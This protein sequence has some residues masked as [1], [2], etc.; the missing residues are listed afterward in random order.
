MLVGT[1]LKAKIELLLKILGAH[2]QVKFFAI[3]LIGL[4]INIA[5]F[6]IDVKRGSPPSKKRKNTAAIMAREDQAPAEVQ[7]VQELP[8]EMEMESE[9]ESEQVAAPATPLGTLTLPSNATSIRAD[10]TDNFS[11]ANK[12]YGYYA[13]VEND[14]Q[15]F[16]VCLPVTY[17][18][19]RENTFRWSFICPEETIFSQESFTCMRRED[20]T[21]ECEDSARYYE[22]NGNFGGAPV[23][24]EEKQQEQAAEPEEQQ[25]SEKD[26]QPVEAAP[27]P[28]PAPVAQP[29]KPVKVQSKPK[30][31]P[32]RRK[33]QPQ[34]K[35][36]VTEAAPVAAETEAVA[37]PVAES[38][39]GSSP[40]RFT[41]RPHKHQAVVA[42]PAPA[43]VR[44]EL[45]AGIRKRP[46]IFNK[47]TTTPK[48]VEEPA[49]TE[50]AVVELSEPAPT[51]QLQTMFED[52]APVQ[53]VEE[54][55]EPEVQAS[56]PA[57]AIAQPEEATPEGAAP[58]KIETET[59]LEEVKPIEAIEEIPAVIFESLEATKPQDTEVEKQK[60]TEEE[61]TQ[62]T[63]EKK[64]KDTEEKK[65]KD[66]E[67]EQPKE[68]EEVKPVEEQ[69]KEVPAV[70]EEKETP[71][72]EEEKEVPAKVEEI[73][74][75]N[76]NEPAIME[77]DEEIL[78]NIEALEAAKPS[79]APESIPATPEMQEHSPLVEQ[80]LLDNKETQE[81]LGGFKP[82]DPVMAAEAEQLITDFLNTLKKNEEKPETELATAAMDMAEILNEKL[83]EPQ[84]TDIKQSPDVSIEE[85][86]LP[87]PE[88]VDKNA[89]IEE[90][91]LEESELQKSPEKIMTDSPIINIMQY[92]HL[93]MDY[94]I[95]VQVIPLEQQMQ[96]QIETNAQPEASQEVK[97]TAAVPEEV[98]EAVP[99]AQ[100]VEET[101]QI[102]LE[103][104]PEIKPDESPIHNDDVDAPQESIA[105][106][107]YM[108]SI[109]IDDIVELVKERLDQTP[110][111]EQMAP[112]ELVITPGA[113]AP[114]TLIQNP[115]PEAQSESETK[116]ESEQ[117]SQPEQELILPIYK[118]IS[119]AEP[120]MSKVQTLPVTVSKV[121]TETETEKE[122]QPEVREPKS[123][124]RD[125]MDARKRRFLFRAD[126]S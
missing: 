103:T 23:Q 81:S 3:A 116:S 78:S 61:E 1:F 11:C 25:Q 91:L 92:N 60:E 28:A 2:L 119:M 50:A 99:E 52:A 35:A 105:T 54:V 121:E 47:P 18:D 17:A 101:S 57:V 80:L 93:P 83:E 125:K 117:E 67:E 87:E 73:Q 126:A 21:I 22:L 45:F 123:Q 14:C 124:S 41:M 96:P 71:A 4:L 66:T 106:A 34:R 97:E 76:R 120:S 85:A 115:K 75:G 63:E 53:T 58:T 113:A 111:N 15:I 49:V 122:S 109:S 110:K 27:E 104:E 9:S 20:M 42:A 74:E 118:R 5:R 70:E 24:E 94:Q 84:E 44:N 86:K 31:K 102:Q 88:I 59:R 6:W 39:P 12:T 82:V 65:P 69:T 95:P 26:K 7:E 16:H 33:P 98:K 62:Y 46:A 19:G 108:P 30:P 29:S 112:M 56:E 32:N 90:Q 13:D 77:S 79:D 10:I 72:A 8:S 37:E 55:R 48:P 36:P 107:A 68:T 51:V 40:Q 114:M 38:K 64:P 100:T 43:P 89:S